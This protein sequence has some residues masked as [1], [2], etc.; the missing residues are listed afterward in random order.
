M[1]GVKIGVNQLARNAKMYSFKKS[2]DAGFFK[3]I[4]SGARPYVVNFIYSPA[5]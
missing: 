2:R 3:L 4:N 1:R 5:T